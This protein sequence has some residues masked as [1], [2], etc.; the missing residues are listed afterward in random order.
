VEAR[1]LARNSSRVAGGSSGGD[2]GEP[3]ARLVHI[4]KQRFVRLGGLCDELAQHCVVMN[5]VAEH[6]LPQGA[7]PPISPPDKPPLLVIACGS[8]RL[9]SV[10]SLVAANIRR[11]A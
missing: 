10:P 3:I 4:D 2:Q 6:V 9:L 1:K 5:H 7:S 8:K 11:S